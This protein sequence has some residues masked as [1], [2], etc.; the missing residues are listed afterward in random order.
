MVED[1]SDHLHVTW[2]QPMSPGPTCPITNNSIRWSL[3]NTG[4]T[5]GTDEIIASSEYF[6]PGLEAYTAY[7]VHI[8]SKTDGGFGQEGSASNTTDQDSKYLKYIYTDP[9]F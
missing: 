7:A 4:D 6:I 1:E 3:V 2:I 5:V 8:A 9:F